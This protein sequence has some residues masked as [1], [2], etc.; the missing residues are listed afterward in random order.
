MQAKAPSSVALLKL[1]PIA[2]Q[3]DHTA[4]PYAAEPAGQRQGHTIQVRQERHKRR[5]TEDLHHETGRKNIE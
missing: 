2:L 4:R 3:C 5:G 1:L